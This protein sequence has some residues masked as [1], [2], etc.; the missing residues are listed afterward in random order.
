MGAPRRHVFE[1]SDVI[2]VQSQL[3]SIGT[4]IREYLNQLTGLPQLI[5][6]GLIL[7]R[8]G[9]RRTLVLRLVFL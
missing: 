6:L 4:G 9:P 1:V 8:L 5:A 3:D 7:R 2:L